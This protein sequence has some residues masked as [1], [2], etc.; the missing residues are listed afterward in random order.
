MIMEKR[1][2][3]KD[4]GFTCINCGLE[5]LPLQTTSRNHCPR[6]LCSLHV[7]INPGDRANPC[8]GILRPIAAE[9]D[10]KKG[11]ILIQRCEKCGELRRNRAAADAK[12]QP[13][14]IRVLITLTSAPH[15]TK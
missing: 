13:D 14:D 10:S 7:D 8:R 1:F 12:V 3:K 15:P 2:Q 11:Y 5:V 9:P 4:E 6:C